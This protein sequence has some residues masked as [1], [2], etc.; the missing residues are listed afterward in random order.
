MQR[1]HVQACIRW[2]SR[3]G[4]SCHGRGHKVGIEG[5]GMFGVLA[6]AGQLQQN[7]IHSRGPW[8]ACNWGRQA[9]IW[10]IITQNIQVV[11]HGGMGG[12]AG[13]S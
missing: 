13:V 5:L 10:V 7:H 9:R 4:K 12:G 6:G 3:F 11:L 1:L 2:R 8:E